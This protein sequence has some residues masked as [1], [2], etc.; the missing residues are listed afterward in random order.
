MSTVSGNVFCPINAAE[1][2]RRGLGFIWR[3]WCVMG[4][5]IIKELH[6]SLKKLF[7]W[8]R[9]GHVFWRLFLHTFSLKCNIN[10]V[11]W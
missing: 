4:F 1:V 10:A 7:E 9:C 11:L 5:V 2:L 6:L 8:I 3:P